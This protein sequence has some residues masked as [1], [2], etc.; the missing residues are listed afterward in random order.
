MT[1]ATLFLRENQRCYIGQIMADTLA[2]LSPV[3]KL[4][5]STGLSYIAVFTVRVASVVSV[6]ATLFWPNMPRRTAVL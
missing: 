6:V 2:K 1:V 5:Q 4:G 3:T